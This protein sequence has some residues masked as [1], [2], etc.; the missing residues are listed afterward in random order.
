MI[1][2]VNKGYSCLVI[3][4]RGIGETGGKVLNLE[5]DY[6]LFISGKEPIQ[7]LSV[8]D[9]LRS[10]DL[11]KEVK[12]VDKNNIAIVGESMGGR[13]G[14]IASAIDKSIKGFIGIS[15]SGF[16]VKRDRFSKG[17][18]FLLSIDP[19]NYIGDISPNPVFMI[20]GDN[21]TVV[22]IENARNTFNKAKDPKK[23]FVAEGC[24][25]GYCDVKEREELLNDLREIFG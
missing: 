3:D 11:L 14:L 16:D 24:G 20:H 9:A 15:T 19:D 21:D 25:H 13:Y 10:Y 2:L 12:G 23:F 22:K 5:E 1:M 17:N 4:Q 18:I 6:N 8:Y 7:H